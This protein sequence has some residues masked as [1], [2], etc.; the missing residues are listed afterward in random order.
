MIAGIACAIVRRSAKAN[1]D[2]WIYEVRRLNPF[3]VVKP[4]FPDDDQVG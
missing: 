4:I 1:G 2:S 3:R